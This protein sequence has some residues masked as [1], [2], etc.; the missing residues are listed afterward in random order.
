MEDLIMRVAAL[1]KKQCREEKDGEQESPFRPSKIKWS[2]KGEE[3]E[4]PLPMSGFIFVDLHKK[5]I[6][7]VKQKLIEE[8]LIGLKTLKSINKL[9]ESIL[10]M[11]CDKIRVFMNTL[12]S[13][14]KYWQGRL[15]DG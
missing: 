11:A 3:K 6:A 12:E 7:D 4:P 5:V 15:K 8:N 9:P 13:Q 10:S 2:P 1:E 14:I